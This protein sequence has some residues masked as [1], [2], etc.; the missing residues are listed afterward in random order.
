MLR[1]VH[2]TVLGRVIIGLLALASIAAPAAAFDQADLD[3]LL[4]TKNCPG[5]DLSGADLSGRNLAEADLSGA[6][7]RGANLE[8][9]NL[10]N[11]NLAGANL[12]NT[13]LFYAYLP[14][15]DVT[16]ATFL[17]ARYCDTIWVNRAIVYNAC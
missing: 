16:D 17:G 2:H 4:E 5:C 11:A 7:L 3:R 6:N 13:N 9:A 8:N 14:G 15:A 1:P 12:D 10:T